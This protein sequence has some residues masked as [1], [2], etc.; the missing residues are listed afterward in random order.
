MTTRSSPPAETKH[1]VPNTSPPQGGVTKTWC[2]G[3]H[4]RR[5]TKKSSELI[6]DSAIRTHSSEPVIGIRNIHVRNIYMYVLYMLY[7]L[8]YMLYMC[9]MCCN[10]QHTIRIIRQTICTIR[11]R[12]TYE[13]EFSWKN[14]KKIHTPDHH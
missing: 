14:E 1:I 12:I 5:I 4:P 9:C 11:L 8:L 10:L 3:R 13:Y 7:I 6:P 2:S